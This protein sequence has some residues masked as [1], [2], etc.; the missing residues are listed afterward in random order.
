MK[1]ILALMF[2][3]IAAQFVLIGYMVVH[4]TIKYRPVYIFI[5]A[6]AEPIVTEA[7]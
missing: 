4:P 7:I 5:D 1:K 3:I 6:E 2:S